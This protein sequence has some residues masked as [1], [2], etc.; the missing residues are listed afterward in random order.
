MKIN[1]RLERTEG[2]SNTNI[3]S[4]ECN[5]KRQTRLFQLQRHVR[6][7]RKLKLPIVQLSVRRENV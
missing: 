1:E 3:Q 6:G 5:L 4:D 2:K 7:Q